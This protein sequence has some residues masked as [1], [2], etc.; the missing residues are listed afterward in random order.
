MVDAGP[1]DGASDPVPAL[2][3]IAEGG[4]SIAPGMREVARLEEAAP[5]ERAIVRAAERD[6]CARVAFAASEPLRVALV[7]GAN[8][9]TELVPS[10]VSGVTGTVCVRRGGELVVRVTRPGDAGAGARIRAVAFAAP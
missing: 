7:D 6:T 10:A 3:R 8:P 1:A 9:S 5:F 4:P 2:A